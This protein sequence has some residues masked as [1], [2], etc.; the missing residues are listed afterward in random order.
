MSD[1]RIDGRLVVIGANHRTSS[2]ATRDRL[3][4]PEEACAGFLRRVGDAGA[5]EACVLSTCARTEIHAIEPPRAD[6]REALT[7]LLAAHGGFAPEE[8]AES[9]YW[10]SGEE[11]VHHLFRVASSL[12]SPI[13]GEPE[14]TGQFREAYRQAAQAGML[15]A[16][17]DLLLQA[18]NGVGKRVRRETPIGERPVSMAACALQVARDVHGDLSR[19]AA[20]LVVGGEMGELIA[21]QLRQ[22]GLRDMTVVARSA[23][24]AEIAARRYRCHSAA[25][26]ELP[27]IL[28]RFDVVVSSLGSGRFLFGPREAEA[29]LARRRRRPMLFVDAA[30]PGDVD[31]EVDALDDAFVYTLD[32]L[33]RLA[34]E[35]RS[36]R[37]EAAADAEAIVREETARFVRDLESRAASPAIAALRARFEEIRRETLDDL[38]DGSPA[39]DELT[40]RLVNRLLHAPTEALR[41]GAA[42]RPEDHAEIERLLRRL[43]DLGSRP[44][45][46]GGGNEEDER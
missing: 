12:D 20:L 32:D 1:E 18:A 9:L 43:F 8:L 4:V 13:V 11:A 40:R 45:P 19:A 46:P 39:M 3:I 23:P 2:E 7:G 14:V 29:A 30:I 28:P 38:A 16:R 21:D 37:D 15:G 42:C 22:A 36:R 35:G 33:E 10:H 27:G 6:L 41:R 34:L 24:R 17:L 44:A 5:S 25:L 31:P 26:E